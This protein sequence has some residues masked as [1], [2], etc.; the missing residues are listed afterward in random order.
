P[1]TGARLDVPIAGVRTGGRKSFPWAAASVVKDGGDDP[2]VTHGLRLEVRAGLDF[3]AL[4]ETPRAG[5]NS[6]APLLIGGFSS[7][8]F[9]YAGRGIGRVTLP[10]LPVPPGEPAIN[11]EPR[12]QIAAAACEAAAAHG[13]SGSLHLRLC[14]P[15]GEERAKDTLN[16]R[17]GIVGGISILGTRGIVRPYSN[18]AW[19][20]VIIQGINVAAAA[21]IST[22]LL[23]TGRRSEDLLRALYP[24]LPPPAA[25]QAADFAAF[26]L[27]QAGKN[28]CIHR[29]AWGC[30]PGKLLKLAQGLEWTHARSAPADIASLAR[31]WE[32]CGAPE[33]AAV[34]AMPTASGA[35]SLMRKISPEG[36]GLVLAALTERAFAVME[37]WLRADSRK[38]AP[39]DLS[40]HV[41]SL[42]GEILASRRGPPFQAEEIRGN[43]T[44]NG[45]RQRENA[46]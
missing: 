22:L 44:L 24:D 14:A 1:F 38:D 10:G 32:K 18:E 27:R 45:Y 11:P 20:A 15:S 43:F 16:P 5:E 12:R 39:P 46:P 8:V 26:S 34:A 2:D 35:L 28:A 4:S 6:P 23:S 42:E 41:F 13:C 40:L 36:Y 21:G 37:G 19:Q 31:L 17:L 3:R 30:F 29:V 9:L 33:T 25:V 7:P